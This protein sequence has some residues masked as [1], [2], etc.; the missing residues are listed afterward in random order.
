MNIYDFTTE[1][2]KEAKWQLTEIYEF[3]NR[4]NLLNYQPRSILLGGQPASGKTK[5]FEQVRSTSPEIKF[6]E[7]NAD[8]YRQYIFSR[9]FYHQQWLALS[10]LARQ[11]SETN[12][13][14]LKQIAE[15]VQMFGQ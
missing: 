8:E 4:E 1:E 5:L 10:E 6:I 14:Y 7:I 15:F 13:A 3:N 2:L 12:Q 11:R 9:T